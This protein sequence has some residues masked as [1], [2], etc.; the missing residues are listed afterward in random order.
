MPIKLPT[1]PRQLD[2]HRVDHALFHAVGLGR[3][4][5]P[6]AGVLR[7]DGTMLA[8]KNSDDFVSGSHY[9]QGRIERLPH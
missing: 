6:D 8:P 7:P 4:G 3:H 5:D 1:T 9:D 2:H